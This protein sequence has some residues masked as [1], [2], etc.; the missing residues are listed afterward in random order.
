[1]L[2]CDAAVQKMW[3]LVSHVS[4]EAHAFPTLPYM[5]GKTYL[6]GGN[7]QDSQMRGETE[8]ESNSEATSCKTE[9]K[10]QLT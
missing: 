5:T 3:R 1:M 6:V 2:P 8:D 10:N 9:N 4:E 7:W